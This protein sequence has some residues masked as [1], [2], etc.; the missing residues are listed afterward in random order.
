MI[1]KQ[2]F[3]LVLKYAFRRIDYLGKAILL[4][5]I[6]I[7][8]ELGAISFSET[9]GDILSEIHK[10]PQIIGWRYSGLRIIHILITG[11]SWITF[12]ILAVLLLI[13][14]FLRYKSK[15]IVHV[16]HHFNSQLRSM[17]KLIFDF[18]SAT[19]LELLNKFI[20]DL[21]DSYMPE[22][23]I[24]P[25]K[26]KAY[27]LMGV[28]K[29]DHEDKQFPFRCHIKSYTL[30]PD[31]MLYKERACI[32]YFYL[33][34]K[35]KAQQLAEEIL[36]VDGLNERANA[37]ALMTDPKF[38]YESVPVPVKSGHVFRRLY[39]SHLIGKEDEQSARTV[40][41]NEIEK[42]ILPENVNFQN[43]DYWELIGRFAFHLGMVQ[44]PN[45]FASE[46]ESYTGNELIKYSNAVFKSVTNVLIN[47]EVYSHFRGYKTTFFYFNQTQYLLLDDHSAVME[48][49]RLFK[50]NFTKEEY[51]EQFSMA[52]LICLNQIHK[53]DEVLIVTT[54]V[55]PNDEFKYLMEFQA[56]LGLGRHSET[57]PTFIEYLK[58]LKFVGD[59]EVNNLISFGDYLIKNKIDVHAY[60][61]NYMD[62]KPFEYPV[63]KII[64]FSY[65]HRYLPEHT[66]TIKSNLELILSEY[67]SLR[68]ELRYVVLILLF[69][70]KEHDILISKIEDF[71]D[72]KNELLPMNLYTESLLALRNN[73]GKLLE[74]MKF[75]RAHEPREY[76]FIEEIQI[77]ELLEN[78]NEILDICASAKLLFPGNINFEFY[79]MFA[80]Y[81]LNKTEELK[82]LLGDDLL[83]KSFHWK[84]KYIL[85][86]I[87][88][89]NGKKILGL[90]LF[91]RETVSN[92]RPI[93]RQNY[94]ILTT[95][96]GD[97]DDIPWP[98]QVVLGTWARVRAGNETLL[99]NID[100]PSIT[101]NWI[102]KSILGSQAGET[103]TVTDK[104][105]DANVEI[106]IT[107]IYD[108]YSGLA[109]QIMD[110]VGKSNFTGMGIRAVKFDNT[111]AEGIGKAL[112]DAFGASGDKQ[113]IR[114]DQAFGKYYSGELSFTELVRTTSKDEALGVYSYLTSKQ[115]E[116]FRI[117]PFR[118]FNNVGLDTTAEFAIDLTSIPIL[119]QLSE[120]NNEIFNRKYVVSQFAIEFLENELAEANQ[121]QDEGM[122]VSITSFGVVP[123]LHP[124]GYKEYRIA[125]LEKILKWIKDHCETRVSKDKIDMILQRPDLVKENDLYYN[126][127]IDT[128]FIAHGR[129]L[130]SDDRIH[131]KTF[132][133][134]YLTVSLEYYLRFFY[135]ESF[136]ER[137]LPVLIQNH[138]VG[139]TLDAGTL[140]TEFKRLVSDSLDTFRYC[141]ENLPFSKNHDATVFNQ[142]LDFVKYIYTESMPLDQKKAIS[143]QVLFHALKDYPEFARL[144]VNLVNEIKVKFQLLPLQIPQV[145]DDFSV[146]LDILNL[147]SK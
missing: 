11:G 114:R 78:S 98:E 71:H 32:S 99:L 1:I 51:T 12:S 88:I 121:M 146:A 139:L 60:Y 131:N 132:G 96:I 9:V 18:K 28:T 45:T 73:S 80:L 108:K 77:Y 22:S 23:E 10:Y 95:I 19:A 49:A 89:E 122:T 140:K 38:T 116:G 67:E 65:L 16:K 41:A 26:A 82:T 20:Q 3:Q 128:V 136:R 120:T 34:Q 144:R 8:R 110:E 24:I 74:V 133:K 31:D 135:P 66:E 102:A 83:K 36:K 106:T 142:A 141:L 5:T 15:D 117:Y 33:E 62:S 27:H 55:D 54:F 130:I 63:H 48:M 87:C 126:Y 118:D 104:V 37:V 61:V 2:L 56:L 52:T 43:I 17:E 76:F 129:T 4:L 69:A 124:P 21:D 105:I 91:Y 138:Y 97:R 57:I 70:L 39:F 14:V 47:T 30:Q 90:E 50:A 79:Y 75:R 40:I 42:R 113:K 103:I 111:T 115:S 68:F 72:W 59:I 109:A 92:H 100:E 143:Q 127:F 86:R 7:I 85:A 46:K 145:M 6:A 119:I 107:H 123:H 13:L 44:Q 134:H 93:I 25:L 137:L 94:F 125:T 112:V 64:L 53:Y 84:Q 58:R 81:K 101:D 35:D 147:S 29:A